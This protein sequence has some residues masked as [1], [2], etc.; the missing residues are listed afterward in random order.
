MAQYVR[1]IIKPPGAY[2]EFHE[3]ARRNGLDLVDKIE[4]EPRSP[5]AV[6]EVFSNV[7]DT[8][9]VRYI[10]DGLAEIPYI[11]ISGP[12]RELY[13]RVIAN[14]LS[15][16]SE[17][18]LVATWDTATSLEDKIDAILRIGITADQ[19]PSEPYLARIRQALEAAE[20]EVRSAGLV[21]FSY[22]PWVV[23]RPLIE[24]IRDHDS[25]S[26]ARDRARIILETWDRT[27]LA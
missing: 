7:D 4:K 14:G 20:P 1:Y 26:D 10:E 17:Q 16:F 9:G 11:Q 21:A 6:Q 23:L 15:V 3:L 24:R 5:L 19:Q 18:E 27:R 2:K 12:Q 22:H 25:Y 8:V 13:S